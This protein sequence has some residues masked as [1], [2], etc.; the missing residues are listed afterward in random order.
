VAPVR[1]TD[2]EAAVVEAIAS[3]IPRLRDP[4]HPMRLTPLRAHYLKKTLVKLQVEEEMQSL[5]R[6]GE[7]RRCNEKG[8]GKR[9]C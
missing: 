3:R 5:S 9:E 7:K 4:E 8:K 6:K 2:A 1:D